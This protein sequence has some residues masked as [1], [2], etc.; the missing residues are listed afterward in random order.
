MTPYWHADLIADVRIPVAR[1]RLPFAD[2]IAPYLR[3][4]DATRT[5]TNNGPLSRELEAR[6]A[7]RAG[8]PAA[9]AVTVAN[10]TLGLVL[11]LQALDLP[12]GSLCMVPA[13]TFAAT[14]HAVR[15]AG[16]VPWIVDVTLESWA[17]EPGL[18]EALLQDA[19]GPVSAIVPVAPFGRPMDPVPWE[20]FRRNTSI[21]VVADAA[22]AFDSVRASSVPTVVSL[23]ATKVL[24][25]GEGGYVLCADAALCAE[26]ERRANF[27]F[28]H[29][30]ESAV[31]AFNAK[32]SE[33][34][35]AVGLA[36]LDRW[37]ETRTEFIRVAEAYRSGFA[38]N[39]GVVLQPGFGEGWVA[40][41]ACV[42]ASGAGAEG[43]AAAL[44]AERI[45]TRR[46]WGGGLH[47][48][49]AFQSLPVHDTTNTDKLVQSVIGLPYWPDLPDD[50][51]ARICEIV[52]RGSP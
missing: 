21:S 15:L 8:A 2:D 19:P 4:I 52:G 1:P 26:V 35:A 31:P 48:H 51:I 5:Y 39:N 32:M 23:H 36:A 27:G 30:R 38:G 40:S 7:A 9:S 28:R 13:W 43:V 14:A 49:Q 46:W 17:L 47:R 42:S 29:S 41:S 18:A 50:D 44:A 24:G 6:L 33:Y 11:A 16:L 25:A 37:L 20:E 10:G 12:G 3:R 22:A 45:G 34:A